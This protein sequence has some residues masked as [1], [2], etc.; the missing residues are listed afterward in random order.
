MNRRTMT[1][2]WCALLLAV[3][4]CGRGAEAADVKPDGVRILG[5]STPLRVWMIYRTPVVLGVDGEL[6]PGATPG[7]KR[8]GGIVWT[9]IPEY[10]SELPPESWRE[11]AFDD[12][13]WTRTSAPVEQKRRGQNRAPG[14]LHSATDSAMICVRGKFMVSDPEQVGALRLSATYVGGLTVFLNGSEV[15]RRHLP[16]GDLGPETLAEKYPDDLYITADGKYLQDVETKIK[17]KARFE[18]RYRRMGDVAIPA[19]LLRKGLNV[20]ALQVH[21]APV[22]EPATTVERRQHGGMGTVYG[23]WAYAAL[24]DLDLTATGNSGFVPNL[25]GRAPGIQVWNC[26]PFDTV[27]VNSYGDP[28]DTPGAVEI[29]ALRNG[30]FSGRFVVSADRDV[31]GLKVEVSELAVTDGSARLSGEAVLLRHGRRGRPSETP[32]KGHLFDALLPGVP[33]RVEHIDAKIT[34]AWRRHVEVK[35]AVL[36]V[37]ITVCPPKDAAPGLYEGRVTVTA[38]GLVKTQLPLR[39]RIHDWTLPDP[40]NW[41]VKNLNV[42][43]PYHLAGSYKVPMWSEEHWKLVE[44]SFALMADI[45][46]RRAPV[47]LVPG[48]RYNSKVPLEWSMFRLVPKKDGAGFAYDFSIVDRLFDAIE[49]TMTSPQPLSIN[50]WGQDSHW[51]DG[52]KSLGSVVGW[53][54][55]AAMVP[56][57]DPA[58][59]ELTSVPNP[60]PGTEENYRFWK[61]ILDEL[62][63]RIDKRGWFKSTAIMH[64]TY[65][66]GPN[67]AQVDIA[68]RIWPDGAY[69]YTAHNGQLDQYFSGTQGRMPVRYSESVWTRGNVEHRGYRRLL[70]PG[71]DEW[72][73]DYTHRDGHTDNSPLL[74]FRVAAESNIM[75]G[76]DGIGYLCSDF[77]PM[78]NQ[79]RKG[80]YYHV[81]A[82]RGGTQGGSTTTLLAKGP[83]GPVATGR[84]EMFREGCQQSETI[85]YLQRAL[86]AKKLDAGLAGRV[87]DYLDARSRAF[88]KSDWPCDRQSLDRHLMEMAAEVATHV[89][90]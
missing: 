81:E 44:K 53:P 21:R 48:A 5:G 51:K 85:L 60:K 29:D 87:N 49:K 86:N 9:K 23:L 6:K 52:N 72:I 77:L 57:L 15:A 40:V 28:G 1:E 10:Q 7:N 36:P 82:N 13:K 90:P 47:D 11:V 12:Y 19:S 63:K 50:C 26:E 71:R 79:K 2:V 67:R 20:L 16:E 58:T 32:R 68:L 61:P 39:V 14:A 78:E 38:Q 3:A 43:S 62:R 27:D 4:M 46:A 34:L 30:V 84:Y 41:R 25:G 74:I 18:R 17:D 66:S 37:W 33:E 35:G 88:R 64:E 75:R 59:G 89:K 24:T 31:E 73:W 56:V 70:K 83:D 55:A 45:N 65:A 54:G 42:F 80:S 22:N 69:G 8:G 76:H